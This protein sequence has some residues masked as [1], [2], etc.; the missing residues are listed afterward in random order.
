MAAL[1]GVTKAANPEPSQYLPSPVII[2]DL[3]E[4]LIIFD[5]LRDGKFAAVHDKDDEIGRNIGS[6]L[7]RLLMALL[8][9]IFSFRELENVDVGSLAEPFSMFQDASVEKTGQSF[10]GSSAAGS[11]QSSVDLEKAAALI[12][13][14]AEI[15]DGGE[16][17][18]ATLVPEGWLAE[19]KRLLAEVEAYTDGWIAAASEGLSVFSTDGSAIKT[20]SASTVVD[21]APL[22]AVPTPKSVNMVVTASHW[23]AALGKL[24][25]FGLSEHVRACDVFSAAHRTKTAAFEAALGKHATELAAKQLPGE[26]SEDLPTAFAVG[27]GDEEATAAANL[28]IPF[29]RVRTASDLSLTLSNLSA[30]ITR[31]NKDTPAEPQPKRFKASLE[32]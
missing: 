17:R 6:W 13:R 5:S 31:P 3:D 10:L 4:T 26:A 23:V 28:T 18:L 9:G 24:L 25:L 29:V 16:A 21:E 32:N 8:D 15:Y 19:R 14:I 20:A 12:T 30:P 2:W 22:N 11:E 27:D 7:S 1:D